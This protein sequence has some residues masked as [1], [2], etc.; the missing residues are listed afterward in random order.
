MLIGFLTP[1]AAEY[2]TFGRAKGITYCG[3]DYIVSKCG[4]GKEAR[5]KALK[6]IRSGCEMLIGWGVAGSLDPSLKNGDLLISSYFQNEQN[7]MFEFKNDFTKVF[8]KE[9]KPLRP[10]R[11]GI[12]TVNQ[13]ILDSTTKENLA[14]KYRMSAIDME[15]TI[16]AETAKDASIPYI[17]I[18]SICDEM[19]T[20][21]PEFLK[22]S[23]K[24][25]GDPAIF[26]ISQELLSRPR[27][28]LALVRLGW[29]FHKS[30]KTLKAASLLITRQ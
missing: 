1:L 6:L 12:L 10:K 30:L 20:E 26:K 25:N 2:R 13:M 18:R 5:N 8:T 9:L 16:I 17:S 23:L 11:G 3:N 14:R 22:Y 4:I 27:D 28:I 29:R 19:D 7:I 24:K 21:M 15:S